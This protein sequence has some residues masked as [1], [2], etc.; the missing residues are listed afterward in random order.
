M[1]RIV[2]LLLFEFQ[3]HNYDGNR[4][5]R[6]VFEKIRTD[7]PSAE[8]DQVIAIWKEIELVVWNLSVCPKY[9]VV[10]FN[11]EQ[12]FSTERDCV[13]MH[14]FTSK[15]YKFV[16]EEGQKLTELAGYLSNLASAEIFLLLEE[17]SSQICISY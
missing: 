7:P 14:V 2:K 1:Q 6:V 5:L 16:L 13:D 4:T 12:F 3:N 10:M 15:I 11:Q 8:R 17:V 9:W